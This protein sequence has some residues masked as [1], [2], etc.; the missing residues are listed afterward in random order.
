MTTSQQATDQQMQNPLFCCGECSEPVIVYGQQFFRTCEHTDA[1][2]FAMPQAAKV[3][4]NA[5]P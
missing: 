1:A 2:I 3:V 5:N 4:T